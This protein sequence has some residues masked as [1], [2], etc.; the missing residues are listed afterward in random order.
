MCEKENVHERKREKVAVEYFQLER[1]YVV[2][3]GSAINLFS[4]KELK[5]QILRHTSNSSNS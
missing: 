4:L 3:F 2:W 1:R 5:R